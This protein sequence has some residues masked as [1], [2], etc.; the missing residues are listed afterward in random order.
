[1]G[2]GQFARRWLPAILLGITALAVWNEAER[3]DTDVV[4]TAEVVYER[5]LQT[6]ILAARRI[7]RTLQAPVADAN[8][9]PVLRAMI[10]DS[11]STTCLAVRVGD[12][13]L[14]PSARIDQGLVP[15]SNQKILTTYAA[16]LILGS[17]FH[18]TT[19]VVADR[20]PVDGV[21][22]GNL[23][24]VGDG[25]PFLSTEN[26]WTQY[27]TNDARFHTRL[28]DL[29]DRIAEAGIVE[30]TGTVVGDESLFDTERQGLWA[31]RL[32]NAKQSGPLSALTVNEGFNDWPELYVSSRQRSATDDPAVHSASVLI[33]LLGE[34]GI[35]V[36]EPPASGVAPANAVDVTAID[37][38]PLVDL[39]T[40]INSY[41]SNMGAELLLKRLG[42]AARGEGSTA[43]GA[44][45]LLDALAADGIP[46]DGIRIDDGSGLAET[47]LLTCQAILA[48]L[49][50]AGP[51]SD[52][53]R[54]L[55]VA[56]ERGTLLERMVETPAAGSVFAKTGT[57]ND[58][59]ALS[60]YAQSLTDADIDL[61][62]AYIANEQFVISNEDV[63]ALQDSF[64]TSLTD[65]PGSPSVDALSPLDPE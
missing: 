1:M 9:A 16:Y 44:T 53:A 4:S 60:G 20:D 61:L 8:I 26:W 56:G 52:F 17:D 12:R 50:N 41:S 36:T 27:E 10:N 58:A 35:T 11:P 42:V 51:D 49:T 39:L 29:A 59:T 2:V 31:E 47:N 40:H 48:V 43:S 62:F 32:I 13:V 33:Q 63:L 64:A 54:T 65:Y 5:D 24:F 57:L 38:P 45:A 18:F 21:V 37:S 14:T 34:R 7:P 55:A 15:A 28:E 46:I 23:Y 30:V 3:R 6:P 25:D 22:A 19:S